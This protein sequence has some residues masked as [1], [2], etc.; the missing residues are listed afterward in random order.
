MIKRPSP[1]SPAYARL[2]YAD[3]GVSPVLSTM[4]LVTWV[5]GAVAAAG[6]WASHGGQGY[7][8]W[9]VGGA[10]V[11]AGV[12]AMR[13]WR[14]AT[15]RAPGMTLF[16]STRT[17]R[18][19][20]RVTEAMR[21][22]PVADQ[23]A[24]ETWRAFSDNACSGGTRRDRKWRHDRLANQAVLLVSAASA[25]AEKAASAQRTTELITAVRAELEEH[26]RG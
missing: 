24:H 4:V 26:S 25:N 23:L 2:Y 17:W 8:P 19:A 12:G 22:S 16:D 9:T 20:V 10:L 1:W 14:A 6:V 18:E 11:A 13:L 21:R 5:T 15:L 7:T 3:D